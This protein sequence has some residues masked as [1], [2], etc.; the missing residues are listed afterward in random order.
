MLLRRYPLTRV[1]EAACYYCNRAGIVVVLNQFNSV[2]CL[3]R[4]LF[5]MAVSSIPSQRM[6]PT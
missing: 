4:A 3:D 6:R 1:M 5:I 2:F